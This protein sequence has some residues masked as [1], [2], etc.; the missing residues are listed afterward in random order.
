[1]TLKGSVDGESCAETP[2]GDRAAAAL[3]PPDAVETD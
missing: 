2:H 3:L 1:M